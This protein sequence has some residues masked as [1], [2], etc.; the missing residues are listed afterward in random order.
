M[1]ASVSYFTIFFPLCLESILHLAKRYIMARTDNGQTRFAC[2]GEISI[3]LLHNAQLPLGQSSVLNIVLNCCTI[4]KNKILF[5]PNQ[6][7]TVINGN[8][9]LPKHQPASG[10]SSRF[11]CGECA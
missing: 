11:A 1:K 3:V 6:L 4:E 7:R 8:D 9:N 2:Q 5:K 10:P